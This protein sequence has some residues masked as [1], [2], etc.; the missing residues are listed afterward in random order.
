MKNKHRKRHTD[1][2]NR[3]DSQN[4]NQECIIWFIIIN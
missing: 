4:T 3:G 1:Y 2:W